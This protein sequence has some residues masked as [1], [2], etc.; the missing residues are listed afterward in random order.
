MRALVH[1]ILARIAGF[2][3][4]GKQDREFHLELEAHL[5]M[6]E[7][8]KVRQGMT[9]EQARRSARL[10]LGG[11][12]QLQEAG[13]EARGLPW[14]DT[15]WLDIK[16]GI[17]KLRQSW[18]LTL[19]GGL[20][21]TI[22]IAIGVVV[23]MVFELAYGGSLPLDEGDRI[24][25][26]QTWNERAQRLHDTALQ[27]L[28]RWR[29]T[30]QSLQDIGAFHTIER[31]LVIGNG[32]FS[33]VSRSRLAEP[34]SLAQMTA[35]GFRLART[36]PLLGRTLSATDEIPGAAP[37]VVLGYDV[38]QS[39]FSADPKVLGQII[40]FGGAPH[41][42]VGVMPEGFAF[43]VNHRFW[44]PLR[45]DRGTLAGPQELAVFARLAPG[46]TLESAEAELA[47]LGLLPSP[48]VT[49]E[50]MEQL[51]PILKPYALA[52]T[53]DTDR[54]LVRLILVLVTLLLIPPCA[55]IAILVYARIVMRQEE[56]AARYALGASRGRI[57]GQLF[58]EMLVLAGGAAS[59][60]LLV[61]GLAL[62]WA[63]R[64]LV[65]DLS[66]GA[67]F[68]MDFTL[69]LRAVLF[70][71][72][73]AVVAAA[74]AGLVPAIKATGRQ[75]QTGLHALGNRTGMRLGATWTAL[76]VAQ[77][78]LSLAALPAAVEIGWGTVRKGVLGP[79]FPSEEYLTAK[80]A[81]DGNLLEATEGTRSVAASSEPASTALANTALANREHPPSLSTADRFA[82]RQIELVRRLNA[83]PGVLGVTVGVLPGDEPWE[84]I[85]VGPAPPVQ[86]SRQDAQL[87][88]RS[89][90]Q[91]NQVDLAFFNVFEIPLLTGRHFEASDFETAISEVGDLD[92]ESTSAIVNQTFVKQLLGSGNPLGRRF[93]YLPSDRRQESTA[94]QALTWYEIVGVVIDRPG[95]ATHGTVYHPAEAGQM[96]A[97]S[98]SL[99]IGTDPIAMTSRLREIVTT[100]D[101]NLR[102]KDILTL[103]EI[104]RQKA[105]GNNIG[106]FS[107]GAVTLS[108]LLLSA[109]GIYA[110]MSFTIN[111]RRRE[112]G[113]RSALGAQPHRLLGSIFKRAVGQIAVGTTIGILVALVL[114]YLLP[115]EKVG[116]WSVPGVIPAATAVMILVGLVAAVG[117]ARRG[118]R[119]DPNEELRN[120]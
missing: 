46:A 84:R 116:G 28:E 80:L 74:I 92:A 103:D 104:Y 101:P 83:E 118:L 1:T 21:M 26:I 16:L 59:L 73:L 11:L 111:Q 72:G 57:V 24:V 62:R 70:A 33:S 69:S 10:D 58:V 31:N 105:A 82:G 60:A 107:L 89:L 108:V 63:E 68:W 99:R 112:I 8:E 96:S 71:A 61:V 38:W 93:R 18:G 102:I 35:S 9:P 37:V 110:L 19:V 78:A 100:L 50:L 87:L 2:L 49:P 34:V 64:N 81:M 51:R 36:S 54:W 47:A 4:L 90:V 23:F 48:T 75:M 97:P 42:V 45:T 91:K 85:E 41:T 88:R 120:S 29:T 67:P 40:H 119:I 32:P 44:I 39:R 6:A 17:R 109:A 94:Q 7:E 53:G 117:P 13:R 25:A 20:A 98:L 5:A 14:L 114:N 56:F 86:Q 65:S 43:P 22:A 52:L 12:T 55:N 66:A 3:H 15:F 115:A 30:V 76:V 106:A 95:N 113:I 77:V 79:G 27:D